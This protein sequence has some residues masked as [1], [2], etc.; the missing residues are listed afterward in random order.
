MIHYTRRAGLLSVY[1]VSEA[2][3]CGLR[4]HSMSL[5]ALGVV[6][7]PMLLAE[8]LRSAQCRIIRRFLTDFRFQ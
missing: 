5:V 8:P 1:S 6:P 2:S 7:T 4:Y 3:L